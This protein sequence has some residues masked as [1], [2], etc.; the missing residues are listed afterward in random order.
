MDVHL[1]VMDV[2]TRHR[3]RHGFHHHHHNHHWKKISWKTVFCYLPGIC[4][5]A[6]RMFFLMFF[7]CLLG[8]RK[9][10]E[11]QPW[12][13]L[14]W[15][16][17]ILGRIW[18]GFRGRFWEVFWEFFVL[19]FFSFSL[20][21]RCQKSP[22]DPC[23]NPHRHFQ[24]KICTIYPHQ[25]I[26]QKIR[27]KNLHTKILTALRLREG[28]SQPLPT[29]NFTMTLGK[30]FARAQQQI[31]TLLPSTANT[32]AWSYLVHHSIARRKRPHGTKKCYF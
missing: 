26:A 13:T 19:G 24:S 17:N 23:Q 22:K 9:V 10:R 7:L 6:V 2:G 5:A 12:E 32:S 16:A 4:W 11:G 18:W 29:Q 3:K 31:E 1:Q 25:K 8:F 15:L 14:Y 28:S 30:D 27:T 20:R 21:S